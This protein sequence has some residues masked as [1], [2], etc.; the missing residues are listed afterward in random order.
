MAPRWLR[1][2][3]VLLSVT[4]LTVWSEASSTLAQT[5]PPPPRG[6]TSTPQAPAVPPADTPA[7]KPPAP[8]PAADSA[9]VAA[10]APAPGAPA[11]APAAAPAAVDGGAPVAPEAPADALPL[12]APELPPEPTGDP[13]SPGVPGAAI[14]GEEPY[15]DEQLDVVKVTVDRRE[16][17]LQ[18]YAGS[19]TALT[20]DDLER[21]G[22]SSVRGLGNAQPYANI[23]TQ[24]GNTEIYVRGVGS[25]VNTELSD[26]AAATHIDGIYI[27]RPRGV[28]SMFFDLERL[29][30][31]RGPQ[32]T[33]R[34]RNATAGTLN[35][36]TAKPKLGEWGA[37]GSLQ[38]GNYAQRLTRGM[39]NIPLG[40][41][42]AL[43]F[44][45]F[46]ENRDSFYENAGP[47][48]T[49]TPAENA[50]VL[51]YRASAKWVPSD[52]VTVILGHDWTK[53]KGTGWSGTNFNP[54]LTAGI[55]PDEVPNPRA[56]YYRGPQGRQNLTH[57]GVNGDVTIALGKV[58]V[59]YLGGYRDMRFR[60]VVS[61]NAGVDFHGRET[62]QLDNWGTSYWD[63][64]SKSVVQEL[65]LYAPDSE[66][67][68]WTLGGFFFDEN[69][70]TFL[71]STADQSTGFAGVEYNM[72]KVDG[73]SFAGFLDAT[74]DILSSLRATA[75]VRVTNESKSRKGIGH[76]YS[77]SGT[78]DQPFRFG[79][80]GFR[81]AG[82]GRSDYQVT[83]QPMAPFGDFR[84]GVGRYG[85]RD[86]ID[87]ALNQPG[88][89]LS[90]NLNEQ[91]G[92]YEDTFV[93][94]RAGLDYDLTPDNLLYLMFSTGHKSGGF[95]DNV[96]LMSGGSVAPRFKPEVL[97]ATELGS[98][99]ELFARRLITNVSAFWYSYK[100]QQAQTIQEI[101]DT[102][103]DGAVAAT[104]VRF[105]AASSR[106]L[107]LEADATARL[108]LGFAL[109]LAMML[110]D[111]RFVD[112]R[113]AD[114][115]LGYGASDQPIVELEGNRLP[116]A[117]IASLNYSVGQ[118]I[119]SSVGYWDW[120]LAGQTRSKQYMTV[121]N[122]EGR[123]AEGN[124]N[125]NL[126][127]DVPTY[128]RIDASVG[129]MRPDGQTRIDAFVTNLTDVAYMSSIIN[130]P[131]LN[132]RFF[133]PPRQF[134]VRLTVSL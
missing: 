97:Y 130:T 31:N 36:V 58:N 34:G 125:P 118:T 15:F 30:L 92:K 131:G 8:P 77:F 71:G 44:A 119:E 16:K 27:P 128:T 40:D 102:G 6:P 1:T 69:Q 101:Q 82:R 120:L 87:G 11:T 18:D 93:D 22:V 67:V 29:E 75:G 112:G 7:P 96:R 32:G 99:N 51:A 107:G 133:N 43:R 63:T 53:E 98:K 134:G 100:D 38:L 47:I 25:D 55:L 62:P 85:V 95:N 45:T 104:S 105:N 66:R 54:A 113:V 19:A 126:S 86:T 81:F 132:L 68:R 42:V 24:E 80:E 129:Y 117:P 103:V 3:S 17:S 10:P 9:P 50:D 76:V 20:Q 70:K 116:R 114:T 83:G 123:D 91:D 111:A 78:G 21:A 14:A 84:N 122:G 57:W 28:G 23:G 33:L 2:S 106:V 110:L 59:G 41:T 65:R 90:D 60:Q 94:F 35:I 52:K 12:E 109:S 79:T 115:R 5:P 26:P 13:I 72:P 121:F 49:I 73:R 124:V 88:V 37:S 4:V 127:D 108:P 48:H 39:V 46:S 74:A 89:T 61:G 64:S 56:V